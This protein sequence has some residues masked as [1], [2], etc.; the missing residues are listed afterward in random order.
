[1]V[2]PRYRQASVL[3]EP[4]V[5][6][7]LASDYPQFA[8]PRVPDWPGAPTTPPSAS[9]LCSNAPAGLS[10]RW[11]LPSPNG[12]SVEGTCRYC[13]EQRRFPTSDYELSQWSRTS[14]WAEVQR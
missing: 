6:H 3:H 7:D 4:Y 8:R 11:A 9:S 12:P 2:L 10:H 1:M 14:D 5:H 13:G